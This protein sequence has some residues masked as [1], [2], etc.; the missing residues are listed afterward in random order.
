MI[1]GSHGDDP[2]APV[3]E[4]LGLGDRV[5]LLGWVPDDGARTP[6][7]HS[8]PRRLPDTVRGIRPP[9]SGGHGTRLPGHLLRPAGAAR[10]RWRGR[11]V[12]R[13]DERVRTRPHHPPAA[14][15]PGETSASSPRSAANA[16]PASP[17]R[18]PPSVPHAVFSEP[19]TRRSAPAARRRSVPDSGFRARGRTSPGWT[20]SASR[21]R[22]AHG[23]SPEPRSAA[24]ADFATNPL[25][26][27]WTSSAAAL[28]S[29]ATTTLG[30]PLADAS[31]TTSPNPSRRDGFTSTAADAIS[32]SSSSSSTRP[33]ILTAPTRPDAATASRSR[34]VSGPEPVSTRC[35]SPCDRRTTASAGGSAAKPLVRDV[36]T[37]EQD[38]TGVHGRGR[39]RRR[40]SR[41]GRGVR[42]PAACCA[43]DSAAPSRS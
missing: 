42:A 27:S 12:R 21:P 13:S 23:G 18:P 35:A 4:R 9:R 24:D 19:S 6:L 7:R 25:T 34:C 38:E 8:E 43:G 5:Q 14:R 32:R 15:R 11:G 37:G 33:T 36:T 3:V 31:A 16:P 29:P 26:P 39:H 20:P 10:D 41:P 40:P 17:G 30:V 22:R 2:L 1:T 28:S